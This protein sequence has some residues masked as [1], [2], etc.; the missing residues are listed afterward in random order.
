MHV[1]PGLCLTW[2]EPPKGDFSP[3][4]DHLL[5]CIMLTHP[6][7][8]GPLT[9][10]FYKVKL[11]FTG[12][13]YFSNIS[14]KHRFFLCV[15]SLEP[16]L[17][18]TLSKNI[19]IFNLKIVKFYSH[20]NRSVLHRQVNVTWSYLQTQKAAMKMVPLVVRNKLDWAISFHIF[21]M[22]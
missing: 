11:G 19:T 12:V 10:H 18:R 2:S 1:K 14:L 8:L 9:P 13:Y 6:C 16:P 4:K 5:F 20:E 21:F 7:N 17:M 15:Y 22:K 3:D